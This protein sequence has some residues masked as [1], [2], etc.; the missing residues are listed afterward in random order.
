MIGCQNSVF[1]LDFIR[2]NTDVLILH[3]KHGVGRNPA[4]S[5][6]GGGLKKK[7]LISPDLFLVI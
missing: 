4:F 6:G 2:K 3:V 7:A 1:L 5:W